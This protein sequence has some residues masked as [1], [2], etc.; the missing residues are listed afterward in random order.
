MTS[1]S[2][3]APPGFAAAV[4]IAAGG[5]GGRPRLK[6]AQVQPGEA[7]AQTRLENMARQIQMKRKSV[8]V[9]LERS[10][11]QLL[12]IDAP[13]VP[14]EEMKTAVRWQ[15]KDMLR[16]PLEDVTLDVAPPP[17]ASAGGR[18]AMAYVAAASNDIVRQRML[19]FRIFASDVEVIDIPE[20][21][22][23]NIA[24]RLEEPARAT[25][26]LSLNAAG[27]LLTASREGTLYFTRHFDLPG[28]L[29]EKNDERRDQL[30]KL[31]LDLQR[32]IDVLEHQFSF[33]SVSTLWLAPF[34]HADELLAL[35]IEHLYLPA[36]LIDL[37]T[38]F[39]CSECSLPA[40]PAY[41]AALFPALGLALRPVGE[42]A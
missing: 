38:L 12:Q 29:S 21:A 39:D 20:M 35:L 28:G 24:D 22:Q 4:Q 19:G 25:A 11:Y 42:A 31:V 23:R 13:A 30:D 14:A 34:A 27:C 7:S 41:Q 3:A 16:L 8:R 32:S 17:E 37:G 26:V 1:I 2:L 5:E 40:S 18:R 6:L 9:L 36:R 15:V 10:D 33:L